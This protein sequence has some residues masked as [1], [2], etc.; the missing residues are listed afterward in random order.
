[1]K[2]I[3]CA[4][5]NPGKLRE[6][7]L[8]GGSAWEIVPVAPGVVPE[9]TGVTFEENAA[10]KAIHYSRQVN[11]LLFAEDSGLAVHALGGAPGVHSARFSE[12]GT[13]VANNACLLTRLE[14][15]EDR[16]AHYVCV[17]AV[18][19]AG[20]ALAAFR[21]EV[22]GEILRAPAGDGGFGYDPLFWH[23]SFAATFAQVPPERKFAVSHRRQ[24]LDAMFAWLQAKTL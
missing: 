6:F 8:A 3:Y 12:E 7:G 15:V 24:A 17:I 9:E 13:D 5:T 11:G 20:V 19:D 2:R 14:N 18:A 16:R 1:L 10:L 21:G 22:E 23:A 4:T